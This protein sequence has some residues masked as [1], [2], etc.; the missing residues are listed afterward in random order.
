MESMSQAPYLL[1]GAR[2]GLRMG[3]GVARDAMLR[4]GLESPWSGKHMAV[5]ATEV[6]AELGITRADMDRWSVRSHERAVAAID[7]GR[8][9][10]EIVAVSVEKGKQQTLVSV[11][12]G[13]AARDDA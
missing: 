10:E 13:A 12:R 7:A 2:F 3:D 5:E 9:G 8:M 11:E 6:A 1:A 4:D